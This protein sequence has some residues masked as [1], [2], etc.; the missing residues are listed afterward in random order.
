M[1]GA[2][3]GEDIPL[4]TNVGTS[5][6]IKPVN[7]YTELQTLDIKDSDAFQACTPKQ[8]GRPGGCPEP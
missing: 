1:S 3:P 8:V 4:I 7:Y 2:G 6:A 5:F